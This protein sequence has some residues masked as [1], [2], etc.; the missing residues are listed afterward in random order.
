MTM[1]GQSNPWWVCHTWPKEP[2][3]NMLWAHFESSVCNT[4]FSDFNIPCHACLCMSGVHLCTC[5]LDLS[6]NGEVLDLFW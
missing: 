3:S 4:T 6:A 1:V 2:F 5:S